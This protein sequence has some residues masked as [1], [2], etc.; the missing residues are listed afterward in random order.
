MIVGHNSTKFKSS[1]F[2]VTQTT[3]RIDVNFK[4]CHRPILTNL[5]WKTVEKLDW[6]WLNDCSMLFGTTLRCCS[7]CVIDAAFCKSKAGSSVFCSYLRS[8]Q[9]IGKYG[10]FKQTRRKGKGKKKRVKLFWWDFLV[11]FFHSFFRSVLLKRRRQWHVKLIKTWCCLLPLECAAQNNTT[12]AH[13]NIFLSFWIECMTFR[14]AGYYKLKWVSA[15]CCYS[16]C[17]GS[18][19]HVAV[20]EVLLLFFFFF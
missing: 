18:M 15:M 7:G 2:K 11:Y 10:I 12:I 5:M 9:P 8:F 16:S 20:L 13:T 6:I 4:P 19:L 14:A 1:N 17:W 3:N